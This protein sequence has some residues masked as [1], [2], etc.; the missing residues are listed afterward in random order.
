M[1]V[2][3]TGRERGLELLLEKNRVSQGLILTLRRCGRLLAEQRPNLALKR[4]LQAL[5]SDKPVSGIVCI[6]RM[7]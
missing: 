7:R 2:N 4:D 3:G 1:A 5:I 6:T